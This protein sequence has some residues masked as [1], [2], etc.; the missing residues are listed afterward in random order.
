M[1][2]IDEYDGAETL[3][4]IDEMNWMTA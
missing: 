1:R 2:N 4:T 3:I